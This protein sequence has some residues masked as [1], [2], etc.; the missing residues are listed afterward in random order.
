MPNLKDIRRRIKSVKSTQKITQAMKMV[1]GAKV[2][3]AETRVKARRPYAAELQKV[4]NLVYNEI[5]S[6]VVE[7][8][9]ARYVGLLAPRPVKNLGLIVISSD[10]GL[11]GSYN[12]GIIRQ[13][14]R[15]IRELKDQGMSPKLYLVG[16]KAIQAFGKADGVTVIGKM[17]DMTAAPTIHH[18]NQIAETVVNAYLAGEIDAIEVLS[19]H[20]V[21]MISYKV[22][23]ASLIP[24]KDEP[25]RQPVAHE[26]LEQSESAAKAAAKH[27]LKPELLL[28][29]DPVGTLDQLIP[30]YLSNTLYEL[31]LEAA[32]SELAARMTAMS[33]ATKNAGEMIDRLT[34]VYNKL[35]Q[36]S[37][38]QEILEIVGG[39]EAL[40]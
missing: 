21:S 7:L 20:F 8:K 39:A 36:A 5:R 3:R 14:Q 37:I 17:G 12:A 19:T 23:M 35:R 25:F 2:K 13:T 28:E 29:P 24:V 16:N 18:A 38:T 4:M 10:R 1:A 11:C 6:Q 31:L 34:I 26:L 40:G 22:Q 32:A 33:N 9:D 15:L 30:M 27:P